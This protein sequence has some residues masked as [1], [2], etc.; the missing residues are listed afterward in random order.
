MTDA[1]RIQNFTP[2]SRADSLAKARAMDKPPPGI[3]GAPITA[4]VWNAPP[5]HA[6]TGRD[7]NGGTE[8]RL[9]LDDGTVVWRCLHDHG[10]SFPDAYACAVTELERRTAADAPT[11]G[12]HEELLERARRG[13]AADFWLV[14]R[15]EGGKLVST[16]PTQGTMNSLRSL[17]SDLV[18]TVASA[19][20]KIAAAVAMAD[21]ENPTVQA[22]AVQV[23]TL[24]NGVKAHRA[25]IYNA[26]DRW[27]SGEDGSVQ[28]TSGDV[29][30]W[31]LV[32]L[33]P[34]TWTWEERAK[35]AEPEVQALTERLEAV[36]AERAA[37]AKII[38]DQRTWGHAQITENGRLRAHIFEVHTKT[39][40][41]VCAELND[42]EGPHVIGRTRREEALR[43]PAA[44]AL[45]YLR[46]A[47]EQGLP[48]CRSA[49]SG[50]L[51]NRDQHDAQCEVRVAI[52]GLEA[53]LA[54]T[55]VAPPEAEPKQDLPGRYT[56]DLD[57]FTGDP[58]LLSGTEIEELER[59]GKLRYD[60]IQE[61]YV[62]TTPGFVAPPSSRRESPCPCAE[63][64]P[65]SYEGPLEDCPIHGVPDP[66]LREAHEQDAAALDS[67]EADEGSR[68][69]DA[70]RA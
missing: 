21:S 53:A 63:G 61:R 68:R 44:L 59:Q 64:A 24:T 20:R 26:R 1:P 42:P 43:K 31:A 39:G 7:S 34:A 17:V 46:I 16:P 57:S 37:Q 23:E 52:A 67:I 45:K 51:L 14:A 56:D 32:D 65:G 48:S 41:S 18:I 35:K 13:L 49:A 70:P 9:A 54:T 4:P 27:G 6:L 58:E 36:E 47:E 22:L 50:A 29:E 15:H 40:C 62:W 55:P 3:S 60:Q 10:E 33:E 66:C 5:L 11:V 2:E 38:E 28:V 19:D 69:E 8:G 12:P 30:L 25:Y